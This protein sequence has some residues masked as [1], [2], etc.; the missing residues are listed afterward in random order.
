MPAEPKNTV[1]LNHTK[2]PQIVKDFEGKV[3]RVGIGDS[4]EV[5][6]AVAEQ[7]RK[8]TGFVDASKYVKPSSESEA[9]RKEVLDLRKE[10]AD[11]KEQNAKLKEDLKKAKK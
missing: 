6:P 7:L 4:V 5:L 10:N 11:L 9:M 8:V 3:V 2:N 1:F